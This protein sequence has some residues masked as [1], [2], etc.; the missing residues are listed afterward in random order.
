VIRIFLSVSLP[1]VVPPLDY[2]HAPMGPK[3]N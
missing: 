3:K 2:G 1:I